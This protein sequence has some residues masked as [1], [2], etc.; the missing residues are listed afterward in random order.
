MGDEEQV[1]ELSA[2]E[3]IAR[4]AIADPSVSKIYTNGFVVGVSHSDVFVVLQSSVT[5][6][7]V[8]QMSYSL[9]KSLAATLGQSIRDFEAAIGQEIFTIQQI[10]EKAMKSEVEEKGD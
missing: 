4:A 5:S 8:L 1:E 6:V 9:A 3:R 7:A 2:D 10:R